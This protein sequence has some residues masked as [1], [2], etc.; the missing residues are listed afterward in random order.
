MS[1]ALGE[2]LSHAAKFTL[3]AKIAVFEENFQTTL[4]SGNSSWQG[5]PSE[6]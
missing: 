5:K 4:S 6:I 2:E 1:D 3:L